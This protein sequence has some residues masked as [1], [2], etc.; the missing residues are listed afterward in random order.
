VEE[1][2]AMPVACQHQQVDAK[3]KVCQM[4]KVF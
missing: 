4:Q 2:D 3:A 1:R